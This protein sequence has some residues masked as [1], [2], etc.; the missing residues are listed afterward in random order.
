MSPGV[1]KFVFRSLAVLFLCVPF[2]IVISIAVPFTERIA[3]VRDEIDQQRIL[4]GRLGAI[5]AGEPE[6]VSLER[7][8]RATREEGQ[9]I[10]GESEPIRA[11]K[12]Q[13][14]VSEIASKQGVQTR[15]LRGLPVE[16]LENVSL[17]GAE[18]Q[19]FASLE[20]LQQIIFDIEHAQP[21]LVIKSLH[22][23]PVPAGVVGSADAKP[24]LLDVRL[25]V[26]GAALQGK[27]AVP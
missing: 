13:F 10:A 1:S 14:L 15:S 11:A 23:I 17:L 26:V 6:A 25:A 22:V 27:V 12:L 24:G 9:F 2:A 18:V 7:R 4:K 21:Q 20:T 5:T 3:A 8:S 16:H 19:I